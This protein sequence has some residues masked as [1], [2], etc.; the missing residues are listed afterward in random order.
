MNCHI[1][2]DVQPASFLNAL[3][4][5]RGTVIYQNHKGDIL[6]LKS[7]LCKYL[8]LALPQEQKTDCIITCGKND[9]LLLGEYLIPEE[10]ET[11]M[12]LKI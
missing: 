1:K 6:D 11:E 5:C 7:H 9:F 12:T 2:T 8:F 4:A 10:Q 3:N